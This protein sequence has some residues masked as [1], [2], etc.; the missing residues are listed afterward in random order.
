MKMADNQQSRFE[1]SLG[2][3][4]TRFVSLLQKARDGVLDLKVAADILAVRQ[5]RRIYDITNVLEGIGLIE[6][7]SKNSIQWKGAG[8]GCNTQEMADR[9]AVLRKEISRLDEH[10]QKLD[11]HKQWMQ[12]S[13]CNI[14]DDVENCHL[15]YITHEDICR[16]FKEDTMLAIQAPSGTELEVPL[17]DH[18]SS[19]KKN[20]QIHLKSSVG[21]IYV[22][23]V[24]K[25][26][27]CTSPVAI[28]VPPPKS[29]L[30][31]SV[32][33]ETEELDV[34]SEDTEKVSAVAAPS[35][36]ATRSTRS[37][38]NS[39]QKPGSLSPRIPTRQTAQIETTRPMSP[40]SSSLKRRRGPGR[41]PKQ[42]R[43]DP[44]AEIECN[45]ALLEPD[46]ILSDIVSAGS[47]DVPM[48]E[49]DGELMEELI[50]A[51]TVPGSTALHHLI[52]LPIGRIC[53][54]HPTPQPFPLMLLR[55]R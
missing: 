33:D 6:K 11:M 40:S 31:S 5:K 16:C 54:A 20:Y 48:S 15:A 55:M 27:D 17:V 9:L 21:P 25:D 43:I 52:I 8:P 32:K 18:N 53:L 35:P 39:P 14:T 34:E 50:S 49:V 30:E 24:N 22:L 28:E 4:T 38:N 29:V 26:I 46:I 7:K 37:R 13:I 10:E 12:Q 23:L 45:P 36:P 2:L 47:T 42:P 44:E 19:N 3:L 1:K 51:E 41:P